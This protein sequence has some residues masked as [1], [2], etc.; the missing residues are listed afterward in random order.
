MAEQQNMRVE[1]I[2]GH[3]GALVSG[4]DLG[5]PTDEKTFRG[6]HDALMEHQVIF[7]R[8][9]EMTLEQQKALGRM[10]GELH[11]H[12][13]APS[14]EGQPEIMVIHAD[15]ES[16]YVNGGYWHSDV[17]CDERPPMGTILRITETPS[18]GGDTLWASMYAAYEAL[19]DK[20]QRF[21]DGLTAIHGSEHVYAGR[22]GQRDKSKLRDGDYPSSE[23]PV[24]RTH[25]ETRRQALYVNPGFTTRIVGMKSS[26]S[27]AL[28][29][30]LHDHATNSPEFQ[31]HFHWE[32]KSVAFWDN[33]CTQH[34]AVWDYR[35]EVRHGYRVSILGDRPFHESTRT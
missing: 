4:V 32:P 12:P 14:P 8:D 28:L 9:Q 33:R 25:P 7:F 35:P 11:I 31:V 20:L 13:A 27:R 2:G 21:L 6:I 34:H 1:P 23:H 18:R 24:V 30:F 26:E 16:R 3:I 17:S 15:A 5:L 10:F 29:A 22:Y 19:S